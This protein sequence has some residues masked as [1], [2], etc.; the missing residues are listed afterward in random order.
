MTR[1]E[2][3]HVAYAM[4]P[5]NS[6]LPRK[7]CG[8]LDGRCC[9]VGAARLRAVAAHAGWHS[10]G[11][12]CRARASLQQCLLRKEVTESHWT[13][14]PTTHGQAVRPEAAPAPLFSTRGEGRQ[15]LG[16][17]WPVQM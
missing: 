16:L 13:P 17:I 3:G 5:F 10:L 6:D 2:Q 12:A 15:L 1:A 9:G 11:L 7:A 8:L 4:R 14:R